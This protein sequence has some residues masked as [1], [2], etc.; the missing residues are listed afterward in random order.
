MSS[1]QDIR[2]LQRFDNY[3]KALA[4]L[5]RFMQKNTLNELEEQGLIQ[6]FEYTH[7]L[8]WK[9]QKDFLEQQGTTD[10]FGSKKCGT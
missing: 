5:S 2:W 10:L 7:E 4:Q 6:A 1:K 9:V 8:A 3:K